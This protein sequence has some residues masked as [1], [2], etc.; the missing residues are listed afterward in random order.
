[1][2]ILLL[3]TKVASSFLNEFFRAFCC[4]SPETL[5]ACELLGVSAQICK[6]AFGKLIENICDRTFFLSSC[7]IFL[8]FYRNAVVLILNILLKFQSCC[9]KLCCHG[10]G[11]EFNFVI[12]AIC[13]GGTNSIYDH[14]TKQ[15]YNISACIQN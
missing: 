6:S 2:L 10:A 7:F 5:M 4:S 13:T 12:D 3:P 11:T 1:M 15:G 8:Q 9:L 14:F